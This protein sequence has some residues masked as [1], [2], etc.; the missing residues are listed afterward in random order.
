MQCFSPCNG[1]TDGQTNKVP[2][3]LQLGGGM[4]DGDVDTNS[5]E[6]IVDKL[7]AYFND[8]PEDDV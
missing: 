5:F 1:Q 4:K 8:E 2:A 3:N 6:S 7:S